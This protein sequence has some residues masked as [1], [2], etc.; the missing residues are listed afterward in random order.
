MT[1]PCIVVPQLTAADAG[2][3]VA[4][5]LAV[6]Q[7]IKDLGLSGNVLKGVCI[8]TSV[9]LGCV[10]LFQPLLWSGLVI[11]LLGAITTGGVSFVDERLPKRPVRPKGE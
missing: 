1:I 3:L 2:L 10:M 9:L 5:C 7:I 11:P 6:T 8:A 4:S